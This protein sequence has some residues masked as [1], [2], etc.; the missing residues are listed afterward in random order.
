MSWSAHLRILLVATGLV[1]T[2]GIA[3]AD[4]RRS[5]DIRPAATVDDG[6]MGHRARGARVAARAEPP[7]SVDLR[8][9][10]T[11]VARGHGRSDDG[12]LLPMFDPSVDVAVQ[13][14]RDAKRPSRTRWRIKP[15][16]RFTGTPKPHPLVPADNRR[17]NVG[18]SSI[19][20]VMVG[21]KL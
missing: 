10:A 13:E 8:S 16:S 14:G 1:A 11:A 3:H 17:A 18:D 12:A 4:P 15:M 21:T 7:R 5:V 2:G 19:T 6:S 20:G 9:S